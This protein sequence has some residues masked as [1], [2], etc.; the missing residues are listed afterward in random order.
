M[1]SLDTLTPAERSY[2][3]SLVKSTGTKPERIVGKI[4]KHLGYKY[5]SHVR[6]LPGS[7]DFVLPAFKT[8]V[9]VHG[10]FWHRHGACRSDGKARAPK[11]RLDYWTAKLINNR[12]RDVRVQRNLSRL[13]WSYRVIWE[14]QIKNKR[15]LMRLPEKISFFLKKRRR[16]I[17]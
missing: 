2:R 8:A 12:R 7:P 15:K 4:F 1:K 13:G 3:M 17:S 9:F 11:S 6:S 14:C 5:T 16:G 10:C